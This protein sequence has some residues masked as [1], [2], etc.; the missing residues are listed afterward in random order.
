MFPFP[1]T[2]FFS[3][4]AICNL[5]GLSL[6]KFQQGQYDAAIN[7]AANSPQG[8]LRT[9]ETVQALQRAPVMQGQRPP[10]LQYFQVSLSLSIEPRLVHTLCPRDFH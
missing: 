2:P 3:F 4:H 8:V 7:L 10:L 6:V 5:Y 1:S 9:P